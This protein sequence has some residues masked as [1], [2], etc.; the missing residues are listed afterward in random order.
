MKKSKLKVDYTYDFE[1]LG[2]STLA[3]PYKLAWQLN[4]DLSIKLVKQ[5]DHQALNKNGEPCFYSHFMFETVLTTI[6]LFKNKPNE[7]ESSKWVLVPE[8]PHFD[9]IMMVRSDDD[10][11]NNRL[12]RTLKNIPSV[13]L[14]A[15]LPLA[16][17]KSKDNFIF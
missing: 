7:P 16:A 8:H 13:E 14:V 11:F 9:F 4:Q 3:K 10:D 12:Q 17:L 1:L 5:P 2:I 6:R 15:S